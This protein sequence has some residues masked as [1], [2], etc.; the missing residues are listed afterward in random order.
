MS[1]LEFSITSAT[2]VDITESVCTRLNESELRGWQMQL[3]DH[4]R[5]FAACHVEG[6]PDEP[7]TQCEVLARKLVE[8]LCAILWDPTEIVTRACIILNDCL[9]VRL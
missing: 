1:T 2:Y 3:T 4:K 6:Y 8:V 9:S 7:R 5:T